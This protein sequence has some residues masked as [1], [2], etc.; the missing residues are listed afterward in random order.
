MSDA[1]L[2]RA[3]V[4]L[5]QYIAYPAPGD[6][7]SGV[8]ARLM[9]APPRRT[10]WAA[11]LVKRRSLAWAAVLLVVLL[12]G[13]LLLSP[14]TRRAIAERLGL[15]GVEIFHLPA[16]PSLPVDPVP[17]S[18]GTV[19]DRLGLGVQ[20]GSLGEAQSQVSFPLLVPT[21]PELG[22]PDRIYL[23]ERPIGGHVALVYGTRPGLPA[24]AQTGVGLLFT[25]FRGSLEPGTFGKGLG[26]GTRIERLT[27]NGRPAAWIEGEAHL[28]L[29]RD[30]TGRVA[31][32]RVRLADNVL[33][34]EQV[35]L[36][37]RLEGA[38]SKEQALQIAASVQ[39]L[40]P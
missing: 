3:L 6:L 14:G 24:G 37:L 38:A 29:Y 2:E 28:F 1:D 12:G 36:T 40:A 19:G 8:R 23:A 13:T 18:T 20:V 35:G 16:V 7:A 11:W 26:P 15:A 39:A 4:D 27:L 32:E 21:L 22:S 10:G 31:D 25:Q 5:G 33:L 9:A 34:W 30:Q 17:S